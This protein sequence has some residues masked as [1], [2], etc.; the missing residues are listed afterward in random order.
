MRI[1]P[2]LLLAGLLTAVSTPASA[3]LLGMHGAGFEA[4]V[5]HPFSGLDHLFA[6]LAVGIWAAQQGGRALWAIPLAFVGTLVAGGLLAINGIHLPLVEP[7]IAASLLVLGLLIATS[8][9]LPVSA[10]AALVGLFA[11]WHG[12]AHGTELPEAASP[13]GYAIGFV[14][15]SVALHG[16]GILLGRRIHAAALPWQKFAGG[17]ISATGMWLLLA[18]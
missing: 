10:G 9:R 1:R 17:L 7:G 8:A 6:M 2:T 14:I 12:H 18:S 16:I 11:L 13:A 4:G 5:A 3:H 15:A